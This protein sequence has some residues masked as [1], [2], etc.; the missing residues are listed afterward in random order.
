M[1][2]LGG[3]AKVF[4]MLGEFFYRKLYGLLGKHLRTTAKEI[5][6]RREPPPRWG[7]VGQAYRE[8][9]NPCRLHGTQFCETWFA[10]IQGANVNFG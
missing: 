10:I 6:S 8:I 3:I 2:F 1:S 5:Y 9:E 7:L 4:Y